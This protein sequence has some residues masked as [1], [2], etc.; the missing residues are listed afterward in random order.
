VIGLT[1]SASPV[2]IA[3]T[4]V[5]LIPISTQ[6]GWNRADASNLLTVCLLSMAIAAPLVGRLVNIVG[7][8]PIVIFSTAALAATLALMSVV[9]SLG[10]ALVC[11]AAAGLFGTG[12][13]QASYLTVLPLWFGRRFGFSLA[14][15]MLGV[16]AGNAL[17]PILTEHLL[18]SFDWRRTY[19]VISGLLLLIALPSAIFLLRVPKRET[20]DD[21][22]LPSAE[23]GTPLRKA[24]R[25]SAFWRL[26]ACFFLAST[27]T[28][29]IGVNLAP[30]LSDRGYSRAHA[31]ELVSVFGIAL[32][33]G[34]FV[35]GTLFDYFSARWVGIACLISAAFG[36]AL[37]ALGFSGPLC[38]GAVVFIAL[39]H[40]MEGD[41][42]PF[43]TRRYF[44]LRDYSSIYGVFGLV[45]GLGTVLGSLLMNAALKQSGSYTPMLWASVGI[46]AVAAGL[47]ASLRA[48]MAGQSEILPGQ[49]LQPRANLP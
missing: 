1:F 5:L 40:G 32:L 25:T 11:A 2:F 8:K 27:V 4:G 49:A 17:M 24:L 33:V 20:G 31:A 18:R 37:L 16:G 48:P 47:L 36:A 38:V 45:F 29:G 10:W 7:A 46:V 42:M 15:A 28:A 39:S 44:G 34:R 43:L 21:L 12:A 9:P 30:L 14:I 41:L 19:L 3:T 35:S 26:S 6:T 23:T 13:G 22:R